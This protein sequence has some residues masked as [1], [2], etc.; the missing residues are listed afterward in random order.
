MFTYLDRNHDGYLDYREFCELME[1]DAGQEKDIFEGKKELLG[2][3]ARR[4][5]TVDDSKQE[6]AECVST[7]LAKYKKKKLLSSDFSRWSRASRLSQQ[8]PP[9]NI[10]TI[11]ANGY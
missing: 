4:L 3:L 8:V 6:I 7:G 1:D 5:S 2:R 10:T 11:L 9:D